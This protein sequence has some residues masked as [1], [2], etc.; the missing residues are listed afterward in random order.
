MPSPVATQIELLSLLPAHPVRIDIARIEAGLRAAG[1]GIGRR[2]I[3]RHLDRLSEHFAIERSEG[4][5][6]GWGWRKGT[7]PVRFPGPNQGT[8]LTLHLVERHLAQLL[9]TGLR[10]QLA[11]EF[12]LAAAT[13][14]RMLDGDIRRWSSRVAVLPAGQPLGVPNVD[15]GVREVVYAALL[16]GRQFEADYRKVGADTPRRHRFH[17]LGLV[18]RDGVFYLVATLYSYDDVLQFALHR[19]SAARPLDVASVEPEGFEL[20]RY[21]AQD[22]QFDLP[23]GPPVRL[24]LHACDWLARHL[25]ERPLAD[26]QSIAPMRTSAWFRITATVAMTGALR[27]WLLSLGANVKVRRPRKLRNAIAAEVGWMAG[28]YGVGVE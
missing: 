16:R 28:V 9:P 21:I 3:E 27:W 10:E 12:G 5:P 1:C 26:D 2:T 6:A 23:E 19:M 17:P 24:E 13:L 11:P 20:Q 18:W 25:E 15:A 14:E 4:K 8:A 22:R 7:A